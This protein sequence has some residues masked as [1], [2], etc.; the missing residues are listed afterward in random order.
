MNI[1]KYKTIDIKEGIICN[2]TIKQEICKNSL[3]GNQ[4][5]QEGCFVN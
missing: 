1:C 3:K 4:Y 5:L 2:Y